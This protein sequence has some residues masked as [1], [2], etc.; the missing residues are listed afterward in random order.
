MTSVAP[1]AENQARRTQWFDSVFPAA[2]L[3][4]ATAKRVVEKLKDAKAQDFESTLS[5]VQDA[6]VRPHLERA[7]CFHVREVSSEESE[8]RR[9][10]LRINDLGL[11]LYAGDET[12]KDVTYDAITISQTHH[13]CALRVC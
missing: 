3:T 11:T 6:I 4:E 2:R 12:S 7:Q 1:K 13:T 5:Y 9:F 10:S 8:S